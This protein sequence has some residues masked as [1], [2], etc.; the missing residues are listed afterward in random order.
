MVTS[1]SSLPGKR[2]TDSNAV[3]TDGLPASYAFSLDGVNDYG[4]ALDI[5]S[6]ATYDGPAANLVALT[7]PGQDYVV[8]PAP[9]GG[10]TFIMLA[11]TLGALA[12]ARPAIIQSAVRTRKTQ[13]IPA[14]RRSFKRV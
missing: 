12:L 8:D 3:A 14:V 9:D 2:A 11:L 13:A 1:I 4:A 10:G 5:A 7:G 6:L